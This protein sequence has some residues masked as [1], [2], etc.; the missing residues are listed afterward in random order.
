MI[1]RR[2]ITAAAL[3]F[4]PALDRLVAEPAPLYLRL[5][6]LIGTALIAAL[7]LVAATTRIDIVVTANG[8]LAADAPLV[9]LQP[10]TRATL[11]DLLVKPG[12]IVS[13]GQLVARLDS[14][15]PDADRATLELE[16]RALSAE[17]ARLQSELSGEALAPGDPDLTLQAQVQLQ[18]AGLAA[19]QRAQLDAART[20][21]SRALDAETAAG[22]GLTDRLA[23]ARQI[24]AMHDQLASQGSGS[25]LAVLEA[26]LTR[27]DAETALNQHLARLSALT[28][29][30]V[31]AQAGRTAFDADQRRQ[32]TE[33]LAELRPRLARLQEQ[34]TK[35]DRLAALSDLRAPRPGVVLSVA[36]GGPGS[37]M[38]EGAPVVVLVA[39][40]AP[41]IAEIGI[42]SSEAGSIAPGDMVTLKI[43]AFPWRRNGVI[44]GRLDDVSPAS[45]TPEGQSA[46]L[47][48]G[49]VSLTGSLTNLPPGTALLPGMT[50]TAEIKSGTRSVLD[51][52]LDPL[53]RGLNESL[54]EP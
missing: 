8:R 25:R 37:V 19:A 26:Q 54:R 43:D 52:F 48:A 47:H 32:Q 17:T 35:A 33:A 46:A 36:P 9:I 2:R 10:L 45:F 30:L 42:R 41:L 12:D 53:L 50:L 51:Y 38:A 4:Q 7:T 39:T 5:W 6:P 31:E 40:D 15:L 11:R 20:S 34:L 21:L 29:R 13:A 24:E 23:I 22:Q 28:Q 3:A 1:A 16:R 49:R 14:T 18:R 27:I 44:A